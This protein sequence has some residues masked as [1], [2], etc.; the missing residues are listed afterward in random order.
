MASPKL[1]AAWCVWP[2]VSKCL[3]SARAALCH[4]PP[5][6]PV[7]SSSSAH[8]CF[9]FCCLVVTGLVPALFS[10]RLAEFLPC[11][12]CL[13]ERRGLLGVDCACDSPP[14][15]CPLMQAVRVGGHSLC[16]P[17]QSRQPGWQTTGT[18]AV[19]MSGGWGD[20]LNILEASVWELHY[21]LPGR[22]SGKRL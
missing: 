14:P 18:E 9:S 16:E 17:S 22:F 3:V 21:R 19:V 6:S 8:S 1:R 20:M 2:C 4:I 12:A 5:R 11:S 10:S 7:L 13:F 15:T